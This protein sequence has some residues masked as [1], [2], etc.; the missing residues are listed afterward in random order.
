[1]DNNMIKIITN[2][3]ILL[4]LAKSESNARMVYNHS[5]TNSNYYK[6]I[7]A[8]KEHESYKNICLNA[9]EVQI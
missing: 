1:V 2:L 5:K 3:G 7:L 4:K 8:K 6:Y 9:D